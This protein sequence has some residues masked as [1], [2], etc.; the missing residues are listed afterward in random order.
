MQVLE[1]VPRPAEAVRAIHRLLR[2]GG[3]VFLSAPFTEK[4][5]MIPHSYGDFFRF[6]AEGAR[7]LFEG[8]G[9]EVLVAQKWGDAAISSGYL[10]G[11]GAA[12][13]PLDQLER[14]LLQNASTTGRIETGSATSA[15]HLRRQEA[16]FIGVGVVARKGGEWERINSTT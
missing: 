4:F 1:H 12:D 14:S 2:P 16:L 10:M 13:F 3:L 9:L 6:T 11:F 5:H 15:W 8:G 7:A